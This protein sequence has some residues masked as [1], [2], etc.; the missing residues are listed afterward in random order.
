MGTYKSGDIS[1][2][3][4]V[5]AIVDLAM[6]GADGQQIFIQHLLYGTHNTEQ[7]R[8]FKFIHRLIKAMAEKDR[9]IDGRNEAAA[10]WAKKMLAA[11]PDAYF[12]FI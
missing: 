11:D 10:A 8:V 4:L 5:R 3:E 12:P 6:E 7:Q 9:F 2:C 1:E